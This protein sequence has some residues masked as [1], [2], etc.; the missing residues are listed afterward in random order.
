MG[1]ASVRRVDDD[2]SSRLVLHALENVEAIGV[3]KG[4]IVFG[5]ARALEDD[6]VR[7][8]L[9]DAR[10][11]EISVRLA[12]RGA[13]EVNRH[14][15]YNRVR[16]VGKSVRFFQ[17]GL[18][19]FFTFNSRALFGHHI[20]PSPAAALLGELDALHRNT[21]L[22]GNFE[23]LQWSMVA[24]YEC[25]LSRQG[26][27]IHLHKTTFWVSA[28]KDP[29]GALTIMFDDSSAALGTHITDDAFTAA[30]QTHGDTKIVIGYSPNEKEAK[31]ALRELRMSGGQS[32]LMDNL[33]NGD[34]VPSARAARSAR[35]SARRSR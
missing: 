25:E 4:H 30:S 19:A 16:E 33:T 11:R 28:D 17:A 34:A 8:G 27:D 26:S 32:V 14:H 35:R 20:M 29:R 22:P 24:A 6:A 23:K 1:V 2:E 15:H 13:H 10:V 7:L 21:I 9:R 3:S 5:K 31:K 18:L 12:R